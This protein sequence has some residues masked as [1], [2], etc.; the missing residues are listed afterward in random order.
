MDKRRI[1]APLVGPAQLPR[2][3]GVGGVAFTA[4]NCVVGVG[5]FV[6]PSLVAGVLGPAA[7]LAYGVCLVLIGLVA[8][9]M[10]EAG[11]RVPEAGGL[12]AY[13]TAAFGPVTGGVAGMLLLFANAMGSAAALARFFIDTLGTFWPAVAAP[14][15]GAIVLVL[16]YALLALVNVLGARDGS[17]LSVAIG[18]MKL[19]PLVGLVLVG[20]FA[21]QPQNLAWPAVPPLPKIGEASLILVLAFIG[22]ESGLSVSGET[23]NPARTI[24]RAIALALG[25]IAALYIGLQTVTQGVL[26][27]ALATSSAPLADTAD[28]LLGPWGYRAIALLTLASAGGYLVADMLS[29]PRVGYAL[30]YAGQLPRFMAYVHPRFQTPAAA[31][32]LYAALVVAVAISASFRQIATL[33]VAGTLVLYLIVCLSV[34]RLRSQL[35]GAQASPFVIPGGPFVPLAAAVIILWLLSTLARRELLAT[36]AF[37]LVA[38]LVCWLRGRSVRRSPAPSG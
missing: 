3:I 20:L 36:L 25:M 14:W 21:L 24:P 13:A 28:E 35:A 30:G 4:F 29:S 37:L 5:I 15:L 18:I 16:V 27:A 34:L 17:K 9:C 6:L 19:T 11:S 8:L 22:I 31:I 12:Y 7:I 1:E 2:V 38:T 32:V 23:R 10:A 33:S 26:G